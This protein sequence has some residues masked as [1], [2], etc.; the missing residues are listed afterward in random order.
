MNDL[1]L[2][3]DKIKA[4]APEVYDQ[5]VG[6]LA[7]IGIHTTTGDVTVTE[8]QRQQLTAMLG[9]LM[10]VL[11]ASNEHEKYCGCDECFQKYVSENNRKEKERLA[12]AAQAKA[13]AARLL[14]Y[15]KEQG[16][17]DSEH[18][19]SKWAEFE[20]KLPKDVV[21]SAGLIDQFISGWRN[22][23]EWDTPTSAP[24]SPQPETVIRTLANGEPEL[25]LDADEATMRRASIP[26]LR[27]LSKRRGEGKSWF[28]RGKDV[29]S[30]GGSF[31]TSDSQVR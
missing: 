6:A 19:R 16:L 14:Q 23:L 26:Q 2:N 18:N 5:L 30:F 27:D 9:K 3:L 21:L 24:A 13:A 8:S 17:R 7:L 31:F 20:A 29:G 15:M 10:P 12:L 1:K 28:K 4:R 22:V 25:P 11:Q